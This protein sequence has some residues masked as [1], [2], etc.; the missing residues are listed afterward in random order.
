MSKLKNQKANAPQVRAKV[1]QIL[2]NLEFLRRRIPATRVEFRN[3][4]GISGGRGVGKSTTMEMAIWELKKQEK[5]DLI[6]DV[7][8]PSDLGAASRLA[9]AIQVRIKADLD[10]HLRESKDEEIRKELCA[11]RE[12]LLDIEFDT[13]GGDSKA[14]SNIQQGATTGN[15]YSWRIAQAEDA[16]YLSELSFSQWIP[17]YLD[18]R[19]KVVRAHSNRTMLVVSLDDFDMFPHL[20]PDVIEDIGRFLDNAR[21]VV[22]FAFTPSALTKAVSTRLIGPY[23]A[24]LDRLSALG[25]V[26]VESLAR[27]VD[28]LIVKL[29]PSSQRVDL[30]GWEQPR[31]K[32]RYSPI[33][34]KKELVQLLRNI[35]L[36]AGYPVGNIGDYFELSGFIEP[37]SKIL[38]P[39]LYCEMLPSNARALF[40]LHEAL[41][42]LGSVRSLS[43]PNLRPAALVGL[44]KTISEVC[45]SDLPHQEQALL[46]RTC[47]Y[48]PDGKIEF[49]FR[50]I[51]MAKRYGLGMRVFGSVRSCL[52]PVIEGSRSFKG[53]SGAQLE[54]LAPG[55]LLYPSLAQVDV[56]MRTIMDFIAETNKSDEDKT[57]DV[58]SS[59]FAKILGFLNEFTEVDREHLFGGQYGDFAFP[60][61]TAWAAHR[62]TVEDIETDNLFLML[63]DFEYYL[64]Y[65][66]YA[67]VWN[68]WVSQFRSRWQQQLMVNPLVCDLVAIRHFV[69]LSDI[70]SRRK[71]RIGQMPRPDTSD[72]DVKRELQTWQESLTVQVKGLIEKTV[73]NYFMDGRQFLLWFLIC[74]VHACSTIVLSEETRAWFTSEILTRIAKCLRSEDREGYSKSC[75]QIATRAH[76]RADTLPSGVIMVDFLKA[77]KVFDPE[78]FKDKGVEWFDSWCSAVRSREAG[79]YALAADLVK[80]DTISKS[81]AEELLAQGIG[82]TLQIRFSRLP[83]RTQEL[84][85]RAFPKAV[86]PGS[87]EEGVHG[88]KESQAPEPGSARR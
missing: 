37:E 80:N 31:S 32:L 35:V 33:G 79:R 77:L 44:L 28:D 49:D 10:K 16:Q 88:K 51:D 12:R 18:F 83:D 85:Y 78:L 21:V 69:L 25:L 61:G 13:A 70:Q 53:E 6:L 39:S 68:E 82:P 60:G 58:K 65:L 45:A 27:E 38:V 84:I 64:P 50:G 29:I 42:R 20:L 3:I 73:G 19:A 15:D 62:V 86:E 63:P 9:S 48:T 55:I 26:K 14:L 59:R 76:V 30:L 40:N 67:T 75:E 41:D 71:I 34:G 43:A 74:A 8:K 52:R 46:E 66:I 54:E 47:S 2:Q 87:T 72:S 81:E 17:A 7:V 23:S 5:G 11:Y 22:L 36:P 1:R 4:I 56:H 24:D 57:T